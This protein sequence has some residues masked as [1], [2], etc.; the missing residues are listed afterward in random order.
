[1]SVVSEF[2]SNTYNQYMEKLNSIASLGGVINNPLN[3]FGEEA[4]KSDLRGAE[5]EGFVSGLP[6]AGDVIRGIEGVNQMEDLYNHTGKVPAYPGSQNLGTGS[7]GRAFSENISRKIED[8][9][10]D[11][12]QFYSGTLD[13]TMSRWSVNDSMATRPKTQFTWSGL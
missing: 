13:D 8:G 1:M 4:K 2:F 6:I 7:L 3:I 12:Y 10:H 9:T 11:L 5:I